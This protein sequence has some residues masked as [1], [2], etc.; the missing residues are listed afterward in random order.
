MLGDWPHSGCPGCSFFTDHVP[1]LAHV[2]ARDTTFVLASPADQDKITA[3]KQRMEWHAPW[4]TMVGDD[5]GQDFGVSEWFGINV[6]LR[7]DDRVYRT[8]FVTS[9]GSEPFTP[10]GRQEE[11]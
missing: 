4:Y 5:F 6:F 10:F 9:R 2:N 11:W 1:N 7:D 8:Y 3:L